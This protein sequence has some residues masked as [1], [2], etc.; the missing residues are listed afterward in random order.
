MQVQVTLL[1]KARDGWQR[2]VLALALLVLCVSPV[3]AE[4]VWNT[5]KY[6]LGDR[7]IIIKTYENGPG[8]TFVAPH[9]NENTAVDA[10][11]LVVDASGGRI[12]HLVHTGDRYITFRHHGKK[13]VFD[14]N[15]MFTN[16]GIKAS[17]QSL[18]DKRYSREAEDMIANFADVFMLHFNAP[19][20]KLVVAIHNNTNGSY[21][22]ESYVKGGQYERDAKKV[23]IHK[24]SDPDDFFFVTNNNLFTSLSEKG[25]NVVLQSS[26]ATNDG[27]L[28]VYAAQNG[29]PYVNVEAQ[30]RHQSVQ[31]EMLKALL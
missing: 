2:V 13:Y 3:H 25:F 12:I 7:T 11:K 6:L 21:S 9:D 17:L 30:H 23:V 19:R 29:I 8:P 27:S 14:P 1:H 28:S 20:S 26:R 4:S 18:G 22:A 15:R 24:G 16:V 5:Y 31:K 10:A